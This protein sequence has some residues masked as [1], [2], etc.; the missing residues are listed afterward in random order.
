MERSCGLWQLRWAQRS[1]SGSWNFHSSIVIAVE[2]SSMPP[3]RAPFRPVPLP[4]SPSVF[5]VGF[6]LCA[7]RPAVPDLLDVDCCPLVVLLLSWELFLEPLEGRFAGGG[8]DPTSPLTE[9]AEE[10]ES[11]LS[12]SS[13]LSLS[14]L[15]LPPAFRPAPSALA[16]L[17]GRDFRLTGL[18]GDE[19][20]FSAFLL[21]VWKIE[22]V[23]IDVDD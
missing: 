15:S 19:L 12:L 3:L 2:S 14:L 22:P 9:S 4:P 8:L 10:R 16:G 6:F 21:G 13:D 7:V 18:L 1:L 11:S 5:P 20:F 23:L 17:E